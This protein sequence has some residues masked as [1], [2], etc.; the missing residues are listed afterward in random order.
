MASVLGGC[1]AYSLGYSLTPSPLSLKPQAVN[2]VVYGYT[3]D[4]EDVQK[5]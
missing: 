2:P 3:Q 5:P 1:E 4:C